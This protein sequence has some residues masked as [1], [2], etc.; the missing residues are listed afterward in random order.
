[1]NASTLSFV[2]NVVVV[3]TSKKKDR[4]K[5]ILPLFLFVLI[6]VPLLAVARND[7]AVGILCAIDVGRGCDMFVAIAATADS[8]RQLGIE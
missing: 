7:T 6:T 8:Y 4:L 3:A 1:M 2:D 5:F